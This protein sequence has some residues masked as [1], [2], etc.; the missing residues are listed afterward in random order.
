MPDYNKAYTEIINIFAENYP[1]PETELNYSSPFEL[2]IAVILS[3]QTTDKQVNKATSNLFPEYGTPDKML[4][5]GKK[6][7]QAKIRSIG[8]FRNKTKYIL[9]S[10]KILIDKYNGQVPNNRKD[11]MKLPGVGRKTANVVLACLFNKNTFPVDTHVSRVA[12]RLGIT[13]RKDPDRIE[14]ELKKVF[15]KKYWVNLHHWLI[16]HGRNICTARNPR[17]L[18]CKILNYCD[19]FRTCYST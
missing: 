13:E 16:Y 12:Q 2:L 17:C 4:A 7:L 8:L 5:L 11:L 19:Y 14:E 10:C 3:A 9:D 18:E 6:G 1:R 15:P